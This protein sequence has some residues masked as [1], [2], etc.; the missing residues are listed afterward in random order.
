MIRNNQY[1]FVPGSGNLKQEGKP[2]P[3]MPVRI[4][5]PQFDSILVLNLTS[6]NNDWLFLGEYAF[7]SPGKFS[8]EIIA[9]T[10]S[11]P[12]LADAILL[13]YQRKTE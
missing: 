6:A 8:V 10:L 3:A 9:D 12:A 7:P 2:A 13:T 5:G 4:K 1:Y 11:Y